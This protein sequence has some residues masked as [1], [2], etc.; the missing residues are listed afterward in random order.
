MEDKAIFSCVAMGFV[1]AFQALA[2]H[3]GQDGTI[4][5]A[6]VGMLGLIIGTTLGA[7]LVKT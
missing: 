2:W 7:K 3:Y 1:V 4:S 6:T 5:T